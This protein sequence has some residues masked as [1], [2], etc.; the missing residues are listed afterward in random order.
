V[1][2][3]LGWPHAFSQIRLPDAQETWH[4]VETWHYYD[5]GV[6]VVFRDRAFH[7]QEPEQVV[8][9]GQIVPTAYRPNQFQVRELLP[10]LEWVEM[11]ALNALLPEETLFYAAEGVVAG[12]LNEKLI[13]VEAIALLP[14]G[15]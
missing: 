6:I 2:H 9:P 1:L 14:G 3:D 15:E 12:F 11:E 8:P 5:L 10:D 7:H 13:F 4:W